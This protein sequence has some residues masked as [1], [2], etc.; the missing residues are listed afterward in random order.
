M[1]GMQLHCPMK[2]LLPS[3]QMDFEI[4]F[5]AFIHEIPRNVEQFVV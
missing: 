5:Q 4:L 3:V 1:R 2:L